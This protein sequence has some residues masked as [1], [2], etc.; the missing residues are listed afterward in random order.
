MEQDGQCVYY[1]P[2]NRKKLIRVADGSTDATVFP[3]FHQ[4]KIRNIQCVDDSNNVGQDSMTLTVGYDLAGDSLYSNSP[5][6][7][8]DA[9]ITAK[10]VA[11]KFQLTYANGTVVTDAQPTFYL[12]RLNNGEPVGELIEAQSNSQANGGQV[13]YDETN[14]M[15]IYNLSTENLDN[16]EYRLFIDLGDGST[17][18]S[19]D[20][21]IDKNEKKNK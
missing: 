12:Q 15:Y 11:L 1:L 16:G 13:R 8:L 9:S 2:P 14:Q 10:S 21:T 17:P 6:L 5:N 18:G 20:I 4:A 19:I 7:R 3:H